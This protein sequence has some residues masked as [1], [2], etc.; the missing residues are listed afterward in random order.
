MNPA[1]RFLFRLALESGHW[2]YNPDALARRMPYRI[3]REWQEYAIL[4]PFGEERADLR[5]AIVATVI[6]NVFRGKK[7][8]PFK[9]SDF[10]PKFGGAAAAERRQP[11]PQQL[12][13]K[14]FWINRILGG[15]FVDKRT[16]KE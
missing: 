4:E 8:R 5:A 10:M 15:T 16:P 3:L 7:Q 12:T 6:A 13:A 2:V 1:R 14:V 9:L 11:T